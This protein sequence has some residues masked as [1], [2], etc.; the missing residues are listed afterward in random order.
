MNDNAGSGSRWEPRPDEQVTQ[1]L[2]PPDVVP[3]LTPEPAEPPRRPARRFGKGMAAAAIVAAATVA[4]GAVGMAV[5]GNRT[6]QVSDT[7]ITDESDQAPEADQGPGGLPDS[8]QLPDGS[9]QYAAPDFD[10]DHD[11]FHGHGGP[12]GFAPDGDEGDEY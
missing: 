1:R 4:G 8:G 6:A 12:P 2:S 7:A 5:V 11:G 3:G 9:G 10:G